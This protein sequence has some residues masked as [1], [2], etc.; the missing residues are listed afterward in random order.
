MKYINIIKAQAPIH[1]M[2]KIRLPIKENKK[3]RA[4]FKMVLAIDELT[5]YIKAEEMKIIEKYKGV[6]QSDGSIQF[7]N[8]QD[9]VDRA[10]LCVKEIAEF[11]SSDVDWN[12]E[13]VRL[14]EESLVDA[15]DFSLSP[16]EI[17]CLEGFIE[18][19]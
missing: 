15:S 4:I 3:S 14:S 10:N 5:A 16:E 17:F 11:E 7:G 8:D 13:V 2:S 12:Y 18:F 19:E 9:G 6:I 1:Y